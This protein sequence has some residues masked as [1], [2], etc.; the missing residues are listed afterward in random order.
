MPAA[1]LRAR[2]FSPNARLVRFAVTG[3]LAALAQLTLLT[4]FTSRGWHAISANAAAFL[5]AAQLNF[6]LSSVCTWADRRTGQGIGRRWL[7]FHGSIAGMAVVNMAVFAAMRLAAPDL[8]ASAAGICV[9]AIGNFFIGD[10]L[11]FRARTH[12]A[13]THRD[14]CGVAW[15]AAHAEVPP[16]ARVVRLM[17]IVRFPAGQTILHRTQGEERT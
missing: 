5:L 7:L 14:S 1:Q 11:V 2:F 17:P 10:R 3:S 6:I 9:A 12:R 4:L 8:A 15:T 13:R 16:A